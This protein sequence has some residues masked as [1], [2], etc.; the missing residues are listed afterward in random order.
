MDT[1][2]NAWDLTGRKAL[3]TGASRGIGEAAA[4]RLARAGADLVIASRKPEQLE[5]VAKKCRDLGRQCWVQPANVS[6]A[7]DIDRLAKAAVDRL[8]GLDILVNNAGTNPVMGP[9]LMADERGWDKTMGVN[10]KGPLLLCKALHPALAK[11]G[12][13]SVVN[14]ASIAG[15]RPATMLGIYSV[16]KAALIMLT[17]VLA[18]EWGGASIRVNAIAPGIIKTE[19]SR[20]IWQ[21]EALLKQAMAGQAIRR[22]GLPE[23]IAEMVLFLASDASAFTT[24]TVMVADGGETA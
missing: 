19:M 2:G 6:S 10:V 17:K 21:N 20:A 5:T 22:I 15:L 12:R 18:T 3:V 8:G 14:V 7:E 23:E 11:S 24:G 13:A 9:V 16:T 4:I 1:A